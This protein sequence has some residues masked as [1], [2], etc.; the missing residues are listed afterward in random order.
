MLFGSL[1]SAS[2]GAAD[3][4]G[5]TTIVN[6]REGAW[7]ITIRPS[8]GIAKPSVAQKAVPAPADPGERV[9]QTAQL[10]PEPVNQPPA[11]NVVEPQPNEPPPELPVITT[12][13]APKE[14]VEFGITIR[15]RA[16]KKFSIDGRTY[17][18]MYNSIPY[19]E[20]EYVANPSYRHDAAMELLFGQMRPTQVIR[21]GGEG[22]LPR[23]EFSEYRPYI[24]A[25]GD[26]WNMRQ[27]QILPFIGGPGGTM[28]QY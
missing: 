10:L 6:T 21:Q 11:A 15:P 24:P 23:E 12:N 19:R 16:V 4:V 28:F 8:Q 20:S 22:V 2:A 13:H 3:R 25:S 1:M 9:T 14:T 27:P 26:Y 7:A 18:D 17:E 5:H